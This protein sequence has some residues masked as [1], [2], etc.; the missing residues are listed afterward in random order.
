M[1]D[2]VVAIVNYN[3]RELLRDCLAS[4][5]QTRPRQVVVVDNAS[6]DGSA[7]MVRAEFPNVDLRAN[8]TNPGYGAAANQAIM[9]CEAPYVLLLNSDTLLRPGALD[10]LTDYL[11]RYPRAGVVGPRLVNPDGSLQRSCF[12]FPTPLDTFIVLSNLYKLI[13][14]TPLLREAYLRTW[15]HNSPRVVPWVLG[16]AL[17]FR[18]EAFEAVGGFEEAYIMY[19]EEVDLCYRLKAAGWETHYAPVTDVTH[20]R[21]ASTSQRRVAM[22]IRRVTSTRQFYR[23]HFSRSQSMQ[24]SLIMATAMRLKVA[25]DQARL[26]L[27]R[28]QQERSRLFEDLQV[29]QGI[30]LDLEKR[31]AL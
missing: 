14:R 25:R 21:G 27:T 16:A 12:P 15:S 20:I 22:E 5:V 13:Q 11:D 3:T 7:E 10:A 30:L 1:S 2:C 28:N 24:Y 19:S 6:S 8:Q 29:W 31:P 18:R 26:R 9:G 17:A 4:V 23:R